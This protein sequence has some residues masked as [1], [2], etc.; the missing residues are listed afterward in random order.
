MFY[1]FEMIMTFHTL[2]GASSMHINEL[3]MRNCIRFNIQSN[4]LFF[5]FTPLSPFLSLSHGLPINLSHNFQTIYSH[6]RMSLSIHFTTCIPMRPPHTALS[7]SLSLT[8]KLLH[9]ICKSS[10]NL[11]IIKNDM[12]KMF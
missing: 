3:K 2:T 10:I 5:L 11:F 4:H 9:A 7:L 12:F 1:H 6:T 8:H